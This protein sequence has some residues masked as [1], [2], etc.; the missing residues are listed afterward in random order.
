[1]NKPSFDIIVPVW[2]NPFE[3]RACLASI[4]NYSPEARLIVIDNGSSRETELMLEEFSESLGDSALFITTPRNIGLIPALNVGLASSES[5][6]AVII[7]PHI[8]VGN[9]WIEPLLEAAKAPC[10]GI[11]SP[12]FSGAGAPK[13]LRPVIGSDVMETCMIS[14]AALLLKREMHRVLGGFDEG[15]DGGE[16]CLRDYIRR[17]EAAGY[18]T[19]VSSRP[20]LRCGPETVFGS[21]ERRQEQ[22]RASKAS[23]LARWGVDRHYGV[24]FGRDTDAGY[25]AATIETVIAAA[26]CGHRFTLFLHRKQY[27]DFRRLGWHGLHTGVELRVL[28]LLGPGRD[29]VR[30]YAKLQSENPDLIPVRVSEEIP[31]PGI[32]AAITFREVAASLRNS[33]VPMLSTQFAEVV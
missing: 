27:R 31:F 33:H 15:L 16:W 29:L 14:F 26:R 18:R 30:Q 25:M 12:V 6:V 9:S 2:N 19:A 28:S 32:T 24:Y 3:T 17:A 21:Q 10:A 23:Y 4:L 8:I 1:M 5:D 22:S 13:L 7:R 20:E 11:V